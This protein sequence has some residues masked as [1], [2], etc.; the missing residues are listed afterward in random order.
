[1]NSKIETIKEL[2][3]RIGNLIQFSKNNCEYGKQWFVESINLS[4][5]L[6]MNKRTDEHY[7]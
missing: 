5:R 6:Y 2:S 4:I 1:M 3:K 7:E